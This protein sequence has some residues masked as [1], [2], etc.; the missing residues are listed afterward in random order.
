[1]KIKTETKLIVSTSTVA[2]VTQ[3][4]CED[5]FSATDFQFDN[6]E[7]NNIWGKFTDESQQNYVAFTTGPKLRAEISGLSD[8]NKDICDLRSSV[9]MSANSKN[10]V[11]F[12]YN[13]DLFCMFA[14]RD[15]RL[16]SPAT[17]E[18]YAIGALFARVKRRN[19]EETTWAAFGWKLMGYRSNG[20]GRGN[21][22]YLYG[23]D[24]TLTDAHITE[25]PTKIIFLNYNTPNIVTMP[26]LGR[27]SLTHD[28][29]S[30]ITDTPE[31]YIGSVGWITVDGKEYFKNGPFLIDAER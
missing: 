28:K 31:P 6:I 19:A 14:V 22:C 1:M 2:F 4:W 11:T 8:N 18:N 7:G 27:N 5:V 20:N 21:E 17:S 9:I 23:A 12:A 15:N 29:V 10:M 24:D 3:L 13:E 30:I 25:C 16:P 26:C